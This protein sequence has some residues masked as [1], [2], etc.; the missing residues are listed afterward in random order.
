MRNFR[1]W[2]VGL[3]FVIVTLVSYIITSI[4][5]QQ[6]NFTLHILHTNDHHAHLEAI[7]FNKDE[8]G[9]IIRRK[10]LVDK[11]R[12]QSAATKEQVL[13]LDAGD[14]FQGTLYFNQ[15]LGQADLY[16]YNDLGYNIA[17]LGNHEFDRG[18]KVLADFISKAKFPLISANIEVDKTSPL[19]N[20]IKPWTILQI[21]REKV[22]VFGLTTEKTAVLSNP[23]NG[24]T[25]TDSIK[26]AKKAVA[27]LNAQNVNKII[28]LTHIGINA[29]Q[30]LARQVNGID[31]IVGGH[32][33]TP[34]GNMPG[35]TVS[36]PIIEK[37]P[38]GHKVLIV[39]DWEWGKYLGDIH[40][41]FDNKG[42]VISWKGS[43]T[44]VSRDITPDLAFQKKLEQLA[45]PIKT[46][47]QK[48]IGETTLTLD[49]E[50]T[51]I[52]TQET[53]LGNLIA[54]AILDK[55]RPD[56]AQVAIMNGG[57]IRS[58]IPVGSITVGKVLEVLPFGNT[59]ARLDLTGA[60]LKEALE[61]GVSKIE[62]GEGRFPQVAGLRFAWN[63]KASV[64]YRILSIQVQNSD[65]NY[66]PLVANSIYRVV[67]NNF[68]LGGGDG[69]EIFKS[70]KNQIDTGFLVAD[71][72][73]DYIT[74]RS[75]INQQVEKRIVQV[76]KA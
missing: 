56:K 39:T 25:F 45:A 16:F 57:G 72:V 8:L 69:Y 19:A 70:G 5:V 18:E 75:P 1:L 73:M 28:A 38:D 21:N 54:D 63:P 3:I 62:N 31:I 9:G 42:E 74:S 36:Y 55:T 51:K 76:V 27:A 64:G 2:V 71:V 37:S 52:R 29:D 68:L 58:S 46:L 41:S 22:G 20:K 13:L 48:I 26:A 35:A 43:P 53:N 15:Y 47:R 10:T 4:I 32:S 12:S 30:E 14:I 59:I 60:Q 23:G 67:T 44:P 40:V 49:G 7:E 66:Q 34:L 33:H 11:I 65:G 24:V 6:P 17:T 50:R 61:N